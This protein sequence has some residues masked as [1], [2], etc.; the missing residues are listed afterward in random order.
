[1]QTSSLAATHTTRAY[2][3]DWRRLRYVAQ[4]VNLVTASVEH[5]RGSSWRALA[6]E[7]LTLPSTRPVG[8]DISEKGVRWYQLTYDN[9]VAKV[10]AIFGIHQTK[11][12]HRALRV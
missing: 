5:L 12:L 3:F 8:G 11:R 4:Q 10:H 6:N 7:M 9:I 2:T 1:M